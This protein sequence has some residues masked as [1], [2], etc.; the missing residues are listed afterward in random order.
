MGNSNLDSAILAIFHLDSANRRILK[1]P[2]IA[3][4]AKGKSWQSIN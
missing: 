4:L 2:V 3:R 1:N